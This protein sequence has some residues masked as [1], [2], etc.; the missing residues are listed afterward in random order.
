MLHRDYTAFYNE[1]CQ[2]GQTLQKMQLMVKLVFLI[3]HNTIL[4]TSSSLFNPLQFSCYVNTSTLDKLLFGIF[5]QLKFQ[6]K[7]LKWNLWGKYPIISK[8]SSH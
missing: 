1:E 8:F 5:T 7:K 2:K 6:K 3:I 4:K